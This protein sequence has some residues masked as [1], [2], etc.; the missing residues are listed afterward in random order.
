MDTQFWYYTSSA[1]I[2]SGLWNA[3]LSLWL[4]GNPEKWP[5]QLISL[6]GV[7]SLSLSVIQLLWGTVLIYKALA[8]T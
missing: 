6:I 2:M 1:M 7:I 5:S 3:F 4:L 8:T